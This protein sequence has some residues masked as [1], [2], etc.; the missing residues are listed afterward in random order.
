MNQNVRGASKLLVFLQFRT[1]GQLEEQGKQEA[2]HLRFDSRLSANSIRDR[3]ARMLLGG[4]FSLFRVF[5]GC[6][7]SAARV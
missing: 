6:D 7:L 3:D 5:E 1:I 4:L 2:S